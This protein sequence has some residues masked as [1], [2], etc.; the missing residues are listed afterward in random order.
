MSKTFYDFIS[1][2]SDLPLV[3]R[4]DP[5]KETLIVALYGRERDPAQKDVICADIASIAAQVTSFCGHCIQV[6]IG[7]AE[8]LT[9]V[10]RS[11]LQD[12]F[13]RTK[14]NNMCINLMSKQCAPMMANAIASN[15]NITHLALWGDAG[16]YIHHFFKTGSKSIVHILMLSAMGWESSQFIIDGLHNYPNLLG[17]DMRPYEHVYKYSQ[18]QRLIP[19][20]SIVSQ[21]RFTAELEELFDEVNLVEMLRAS[22]SIDCN[23]SGSAEWM[24]AWNALEQVELAGD[25]DYS[26]YNRDSYY[27]KQ[28]NL[29]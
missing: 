26:K 20:R 11:E 16:G 6:S 21:K 3:N 7:N 1:T 13:S 19:F 25:R 9:P 15:S 17:L 24:A 5:E 2:L 28:L 14:A 18:P 8:E 27:L 10:E 12:A 4:Y 22:Y 29:E 23:F